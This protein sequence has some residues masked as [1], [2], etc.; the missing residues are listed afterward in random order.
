VISIRLGK[1]FKGRKH[2]KSSSNNHSASN[3]SWRSG[4]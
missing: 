3:D 1:Q 4:S 2:E